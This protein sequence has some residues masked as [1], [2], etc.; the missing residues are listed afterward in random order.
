MEL[1]IRLIYGES[2]EGV[3]GDEAMEYHVG[4][5]ESLNTLYFHSSAANDQNGRYPT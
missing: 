1:F 5:L 3:M 4:K 2:G